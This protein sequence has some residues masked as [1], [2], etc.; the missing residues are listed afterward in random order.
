[1][2]PSESFTLSTSKEKFKK[3]ATYAKVDATSFK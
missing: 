2:L 3:K 1:M